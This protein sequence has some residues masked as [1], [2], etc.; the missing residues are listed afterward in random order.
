M[1]GRY[2]ANMLEADA[3]RQIGAIAPEGQKWY[4]QQ[5]LA[6]SRAAEITKELLVKEGVAEAPWMPAVADL[7]AL[8]VF[9]NPTLNKGL[10][11]KD[12]SALAQLKKAATKGS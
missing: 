6:S 9:V 8:D 12:P 11:G 7:N 4:L 5:D 10:Q 3:L 2:Y 1:T